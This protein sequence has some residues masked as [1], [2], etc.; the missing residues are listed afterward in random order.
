MCKAGARGSRQ[1]FQYKA[2]LEDPRTP[3][4]TDSL[5]SVS[6]IGWYESRHGGRGPSR[7]ESDVDRKRVSETPII[8]EPQ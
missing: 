8:H 2:S 4:Y 6:V 1:G 5:Y 7:T 3:R